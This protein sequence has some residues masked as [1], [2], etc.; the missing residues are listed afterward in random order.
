MKP[1]LLLGDEPRIVVAVARSLHA[2]GVPV[3]V[4][5]MTSGAPRIVSTAVRRW[6]RFLDSPGGDDALLTT[7]LE[8]IGTYGYD[9]LI[10][11]SDTALAV[12]AK[13]YGA[14]PAGVRLGCPEPPTVLAVLDKARTLEA[15]AA[16][17]VPVPEDYRFDSRNACDHDAA[18]MRFPVIAKPREKRRPADAGF[19][20]RRFETIDEL[21]SA[22]TADAS[23]GVRHLIQEF[24]PGHGV[25]IE[26]IMHD[27][28]PLALFQHRRVK[29]FPASGG[30][31]VVAISEPVNHVLAEHAVRLL[32]ALSWSGVAMVEFRVDDERGRVALMEINGRYWGSL[33]LSLRAGVDFPWYAWQLAHGEQPC[34]P[35]AYRVGVRVRWSAGA[36]Q[37]L[38]AVAE[39]APASAFS[40]ELSAAVRDF[41]SPTRDMLWSA[42]DPRPAVDEMIRTMKSLGRTALKR[43]LRSVAP[44]RIAVLWKRSRLLSPLC[45]RPYLR[46]AILRMLGLKRH[47]WPHDWPAARSVLFVCHGNIIRSPMAAAL[48]RNAMERWGRPMEIESAGLHAHV[49]QGPD[50]R[51]VAAAE[52]LGV[53]LR[54][55]RANP[56]TPELARRA[57]LIV[58][59]DYFNEAE[60]M[61][62][63]PEART[64]IALLGACRDQGGEG[65]EIDDPYREDLDAVRRCYD[66]LRTCIAALAVRLAAPEERGQSAAPLSESPMHS[67]NPS[68]DQTSDRGNKRGALW[69]SSVS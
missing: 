9:Y 12:L 29:E 63:Y 30:V 14:F 43:R 49:D 36:F 61:A 20:V 56:M 21:R 53:S 16:C 58:V 5:A 65:C 19:K 7:M 10:P 50:P 42:R 31:S 24:C 41:L 6:S 28:Q 64:K 51:A 54:R 27:G 13:H 37:R 15:A 40:R 26:A 59:M 44:R 69:N 46:N 52:E 17:G 25:G 22:W 34:C 1:V 66:R 39:E 32:Q 8:A 60:V 68:A 18:R 3:D 67:P 33:A 2:R 38:G 47:R 45:R 11:A 48:L 55:H 57:D 4:A 35:P 62:R 23:F